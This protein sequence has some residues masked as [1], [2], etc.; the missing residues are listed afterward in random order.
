M[1]RRQA[2]IAT[3]A[4]AFM[5]FVSTQS[6]ARA[7]VASSGG[8]G[9]RNSRRRQFLIA[10]GAVLAAPLQALAQQPSAAIPR[11][12]FLGVATPAAWA[13]RVDALRAGFRDLGY[14]EGKNIVIEYRFA[15]G[16]YDRLPELA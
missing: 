10:T 13:P 7:V 15:E 9:L 8:A 2:T 3:T 11:I 14:V 4:L 5:P 12:G 6:A 16:K 1:K